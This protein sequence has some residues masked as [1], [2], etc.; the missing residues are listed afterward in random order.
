VQ[1]LLGHAKL[2][3]TI[4]VYARVPGRIARGAE[5]GGRVV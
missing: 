1:E 4:E 2:D 5:P 3:T